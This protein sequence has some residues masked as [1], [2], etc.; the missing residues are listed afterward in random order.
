M[1]TISLCIIARDEER[2]I[3]EC[4]ASAQDVV[5]EIIVVDTGSIDKTKEIARKFT[6]KILDFP[7]VNDFSK[8]RNFSFAQAT[9]DY[10][11]WL[12]ADDILLPADRDKLKA[13][14]KSIDPSVEGV[15]MKY[16]TGFDAEG[17]VT[18]SFFRERMVKRACH[19]VWK[20]PVHEYLETSGNIIES[21]VCVTHT[22]KSIEP[23]KRNLAIYE[24]LLSAGEELSSRGLYYYARELKDNGMYEK[25]AHY[26]LL[27]LDMGKGWAEDNITACAEL[28]K[29]YRQKQM[30]KEE[31]LALFRSF[32]YDTPRAEICC[33][34]GYLYKSENDYLKAIFW[35]KL[36]STLEKPR[37]W[38]F[39]E[40]ECWGYIPYIELVV[41]YDR[42]GM[43]QQA[44]SY[45]ELAAK[46]KPMA[47]AVE[48]NRKYFRS[49][50]EKGGI[51]DAL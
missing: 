44:E 25:A 39:R 5:D 38:G 23:S 24:K 29:C 42:L 48:H 35:F 28:A 11:L 1:Q 49:L 32:L 47:P 14:K 15:M 27:F 4:L 30:R 22:K 7:W 16:N 50:K 10:I 17:N 9:M 8:A 34:L 31:L 51:G 18:F 45:N 19:F 21:D 33:A 41:C 13:L 2:A 43:R 46:L 26:F 40:E 20:E 3:G 37:G 6:D 36:A 12:D